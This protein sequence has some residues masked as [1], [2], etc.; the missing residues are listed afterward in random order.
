MRAIDA[1]KLLEILQHN[2][3]ISKNNP[4]ENQI[5]VVDIDAV[6]ECVNNQPTLRE[7]N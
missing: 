6:I 2:K 3:R 4:K 7:L 1:D 5:I